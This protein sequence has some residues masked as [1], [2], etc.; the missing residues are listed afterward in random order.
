MAKLSWRMTFE[1]FMARGEELSKEAGVQDTLHKYFRSHAARLHRAC[2]LFSLFATLGDVLEIGPFF[3][4]TPFMLRP[5]STSY[6]VLE[7]DD[8]AAY[9]LDALYQRHSIALT[10]V[11]FFELFGPTASATHK[12]PLPDSSFDTVLCWETME[13]LN[14]NP[15]KF[16]RELHRVLKP[17]GR[18]CLTVPNKASFQSLVALSTGRR[19]KGLIDDFFTFENY[20]SKGKTAFY[21]F[22]WREYSP[23]ELS[24]LF[25]RIGFKVQACSSFTAFRDEGPVGM[26]RKFARSLSQIGTSIFP[27]YGTNVYLVA[28]K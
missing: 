19:E 2:E 11:D 13:H 25:T 26:G 21:G 20:Q 4:Y 10:Y 24:Y 22:H 16:T 8:P 9:P 12:L 18:A 23:P 3:G 17:G 27:R 7:G 1:Q 28:I 14:F 5:H 15:V 6:I